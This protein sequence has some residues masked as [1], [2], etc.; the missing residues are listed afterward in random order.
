MTL[1]SKFFLISLAHQ[2]QL[3]P[4]QFTDLVIIPA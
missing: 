4:V 1:N 2:K 3:L